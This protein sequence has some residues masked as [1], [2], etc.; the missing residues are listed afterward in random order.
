MDETAPGFRRLVILLNAGYRPAL[1]SQLDGIL[2]QRRLGWLRHTTAICY[3]NG[4]VV[5]LPR[6]K[7]IRVR[8]FDPDE[9]LLQTIRLLR[10]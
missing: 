6:G 2:L 9:A 4:T 3:D 1:P 8:S 5:F 7:E 10:S